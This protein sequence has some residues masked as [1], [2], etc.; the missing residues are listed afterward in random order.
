MLP[1]CVL[2]AWQECAGLKHELLQHP[3]GYLPPYVPLSWNKGGKKRCKGL[4][5]GSL[6][7]ELA[8][9]RS[10]VG[11]RHDVFPPSTALLWLHYILIC[12]WLPP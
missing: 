4:R 12:L 2:L 9:G 8:A 6:A 1:L 7:A 11:H 3:P 10:V 5:T